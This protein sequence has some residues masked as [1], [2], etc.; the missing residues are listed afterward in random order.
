MV[1]W[2]TTNNRQAMPCSDGSDNT[3]TAISAKDI[4]TPCAESRRDLWHGDDNGFGK[5][6]DVTT[7]QRLAPVADRHR[8]QVGCACPQEVITP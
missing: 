5:L 1:T 8:Q 2:R 4:Y 6:G 7:T 3:W